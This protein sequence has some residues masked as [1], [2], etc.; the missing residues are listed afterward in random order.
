MKNRLAA[1]SGW[2]ER[3]YL[4]NEQRAM[5]RRELSDRRLAAFKDR[6]LQDAFLKR[7]ESALT[8]LRTKEGVSPDPGRSQSRISAL[9]KAL[10][11]AEHA[12]HAMEQPERAAIEHGRNGQLVAFMQDVEQMR[13]QA[14]LAV[15]GL[16]MPR[17]AHDPGPGGQVRFMVHH[18]AEGWFYIFDRKP[19]AK[20][21]GA[22]FA[23]V[24]IV[25]DQ[26][27]RPDIKRHALSTILKRAGF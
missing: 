6:D 4:T 26:L 9:H 27:G 1:K 18:L 10:I 20:E 15:E 19:S 17:G 12:L 22:F 2:V 23:V 21:D 14:A 11:K 13:E 5:I 3:E 16:K 25:L 8:Y 7:I 24:N